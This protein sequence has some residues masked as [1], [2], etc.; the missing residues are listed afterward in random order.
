M[1]W[2]VN[3]V[4]RPAAVKTALVQQFENAKKSTANVPHELAS[5]GLI[6]QIVNDQLDFLADV[7]NVAVNVAANGSAYKSGQNGS[8]SVRVSVEPLH[9][10]VG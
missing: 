10:W 8:S 9:G 5:V 6:E 1:S 3:A 4:G 7:P 2:S